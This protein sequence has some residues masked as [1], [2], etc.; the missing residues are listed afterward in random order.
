MTH[1]PAVSATARRRPAGPLPRLALW[2]RS[3][4][5]AVAVGMAFGVLA[6]GAALAAFDL[7]AVAARARAMA[8]QPY[9]APAPTGNGKLLALSYDDYR[10]IRFRPEAS[11]W[12]REG[13]P[14]ELQFFHVG[15]GFAHPVELHEVVAGQARPLDIPRASFNY[16]RAAPAVAGQD[17]AEVAGFRVHAPINATTYKDEVIVFL[18]A[19]YFRAVGA[20]QHY[21]LSARGLGVDTSGGPNGEEFPA[22][23]AYWIERPA[24]DA[25]ALTVYAL[26]NGPRVTG[27]YRFVIR[28]GSATEVEVRSR[29]FLRAPATLGIAP[30]TSMYFGGENSPPRGDFRPEVHD[31]DGLQI[32]TGSGEWLW[33]PLINPPRPFTTSFSMQGLR[34]FGLMQRDRNFFS[35]EDPEARYDRRPG[36]WITPI[37]DWG[38]GRVE[39]MQFHTEDETNDNTAAYWVPA[40]LPARGEPLAMDYLMRW[41]GDEQQK[42][43]AGWVTQTRIGRGYEQPRPGEIQFHVDFMGTALA[44]LPDDSPPTPEVTTSDNV[45]VLLANVYRHPITKGWRMTLKV[46]NRNATQPTELRAYL[47]RGSDVVSETWTYALPPR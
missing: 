39:L 3:V 7:D 40:R 45:R 17:R 11:L 10:D 4:V 30:L 23:E 32:E 33:R 27:A 2:S 47:R 46:E 44:Q 18:G 6:P 34:G 41:Q 20:G 9:R 26:L 16:G 31:S 36:V 8:L 43:P 25:Q 35:Y 29:L 37:G 24:G 14:F 42:P 38:P 21:G 12:R 19:S 28:P 22:F 1:P 15:R 5:R 13:L